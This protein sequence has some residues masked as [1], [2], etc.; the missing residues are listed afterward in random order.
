MTL[1]YVDPN[2]IFTPTANAI[3]PFTWLADVRS[4]LEFLVDPPGC[5]VS[6]VANQTISTSSLTAINFTDA[7]LRDTD[8]FHDPSSS[9]NYMT[10]PTGFGG[11]Y[12][13]GG[14][15]SFGV[16]APGYR[17]IAISVNGS[18]VNQGRE[19]RD[20]STSHDTQV[21]IHAPVQLAAGDHVE[22]LVDQTS[23][24]ALNVFDC[25]GW[26]SWMGRV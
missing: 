1:P 22:I 7:D 26:L 23:G 20:A 13:A 12:W 24:S 18:V 25:V 10:V 17:Q 9:P 11:W 19:L 14:A 4:C 21:H 15:A 16:Y 2:T 6:Q 8:G 3:L 5:V